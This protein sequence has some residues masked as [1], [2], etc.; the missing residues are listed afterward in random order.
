M[1]LLSVRAPP[2][3]VWGC[4]FFFFFL[5]G[6]KFWEWFRSKVNRI[7]AASQIII[8]LLQFINRVKM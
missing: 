3:A 4:R 5:C 7:I 6:L 2:E 1:I 8:D